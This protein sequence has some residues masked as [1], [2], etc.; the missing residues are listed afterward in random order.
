MLTINTSSSTTR[1]EME[2]LMLVED[3]NIWLED[4]KRKVAVRL[5][6]PTDR[7][8]TSREDLLTLEQEGVNWAKF[9]CQRNLILYVEYTEFGAYFSVYDP[10]LQKNIIEECVKWTTE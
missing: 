8:I 10:D 5:L 9:P 1:V 4:G 7:A 3:G 6:P 2:V